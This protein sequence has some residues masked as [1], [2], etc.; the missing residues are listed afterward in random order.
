MR[1]K[2]KN[3]PTIRVQARYYGPHKMKSKSMSIV[4]TTPEEIMAI[5]RRELD[6]SA[7]AKP[8]VPANCQ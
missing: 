5:I 3:I 6:K 8:Q 4:G 1:L 2:D 7:K